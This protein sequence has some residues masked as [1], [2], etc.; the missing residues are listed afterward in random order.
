MINGLNSQSHG[1]NP[2]LPKARNYSATFSFVLSMPN[3]IGKKGRDF[4]SIF[5]HGNK[6][7]NG[8][9]SGIV[10]DSCYIVII[11]L[12]ASQEDLPSA[13]FTSGLRAD[14]AMTAQGRGERSFAIMFRRRRR[15]V[16]KGLDIE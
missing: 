9:F 14:N 1:P 5:A 8:L 16:E 15:A 13:L 6:L 3:S 2:L 11:E 7:K 4:S 12:K 10:L